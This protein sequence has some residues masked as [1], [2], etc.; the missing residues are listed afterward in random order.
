MT[1]NLFLQGV[2]YSVTVNE[3]GNGYQVTNLATGVVEYTN[4]SLPRC[5]IIAEESEDYLSR[6]KQ[7]EELKE[8][9]SARVFTFPPKDN[10]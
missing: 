9:T 1:D 7:E 5:L 3:E 2:N 10:S 4:T 8:A 6:R